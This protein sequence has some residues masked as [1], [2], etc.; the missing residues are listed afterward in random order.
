MTEARQG[1][2]SPEDLEAIRLAKTRLMRVCRLDGPAA[3]Q[4]LARAAQ[5]QQAALVAVAMRVL[6]ASLQDLAAGRVVAAGQPGQ[7]QRPPANKPRKPMH[8]RAH[9]KPWQRRK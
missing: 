1:G 3:E 6:A 2:K 7:T 5:E 8:Q 9:G 4:A